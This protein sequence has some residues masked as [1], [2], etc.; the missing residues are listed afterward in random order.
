VSDRPS[1]I[2]CWDYQNIW[3]DLE[4]E[5]EERIEEQE[6]LAD[7][8]ETRGYLRSLSYPEYLQ[9]A[10]WARMRSIARYRAGWQCQRCGNEEGRR[11]DVHHLTYER[12][13]C[14]ED[15]DLIVLCSLCHALEHDATGNLAIILQHAS[16]LGFTDREAERL[17]RKDKAWA[18][19]VAASLRAMHSVRKR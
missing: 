11:L 14:E 9:S 1:F 4:E 8:Y 7:P 3:R 16:S 15:T 2:G 12:L 18:A 17:C 6:E 10:H 19:T 13:G 5:I